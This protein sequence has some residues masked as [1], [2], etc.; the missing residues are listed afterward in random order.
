MAWLIIA[1]VAYLPITYR[2]HRRLDTLE[3]EIK[4]LNDEDDEHKGV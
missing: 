3:K 1:A 4:R 2:I